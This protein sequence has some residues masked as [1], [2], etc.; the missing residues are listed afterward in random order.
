MGSE[1]FSWEYIL[2]TLVSGGLITGLIEIIRELTGSRS[3]VKEKLTAD[4]TDLSRLLLE[5]NHAGDM[6]M[7]ENLLSQVR[8]IQEEKKI[9]R[10]K[11][12]LLY[13]RAVD[14]EKMIARQ[15]VTIDAYKNEQTRMKKEIEKFKGPTHTVI[16]A[17]IHT[18]EVPNAPNDS[19]D[20][21]SV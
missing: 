15:E 1:M 12:D 3:R 19:T 11:N 16:Q 6:L 20:E 5:Q 21:A 13:E 2:G 4:E 9:L 17:E 18:E 10:E 7:R 14:Q 8:E